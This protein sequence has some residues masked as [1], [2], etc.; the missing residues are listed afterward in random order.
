MPAEKARKMCPAK[1]GLTFTIPAGFPAPLYDFSKNPL[2]EEGF[3]LGKMLF[4]DGR[5]SKD[6]NYPCSSVITRLLYLALMIMI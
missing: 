2:T 1:T 4:Y 5:L 3:Q 6:G